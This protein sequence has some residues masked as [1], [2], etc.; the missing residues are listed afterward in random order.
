MSFDLSQFNIMQVYN[1]LEDYKKNM[2]TS[3][4]YTKSGLVVSSGVFHL[5][6]A[7][8]LKRMVVECDY[9]ILVVTNADEY[10]SV[11]DRGL[12]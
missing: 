6:L 9:R 11:H 4:L 7:A 5:G 10:S 12:R 3:Q 8:I 1:G 2:K